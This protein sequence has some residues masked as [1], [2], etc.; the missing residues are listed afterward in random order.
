MLDLNF[1]GNGS[2]VSFAG[3]KSEQ[4]RGMFSDCHTTT[5]CTRKQ[6]MT[7]LSLFVIKVLKIKFEVKNKEKNAGNGGQKSKLLAGYLDPKQYAV[8]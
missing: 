1:T 6:K 5:T 4:K 8:G 3:D 2:V 7:N